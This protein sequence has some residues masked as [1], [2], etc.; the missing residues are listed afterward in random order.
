MGGKAHTRTTRTVPRRPAGHEAGSADE[1]EV[2]LDLAVAFE[3]LL[4]AV[5]LLA[6]AAGS[7]PD[8]LHELAELRAMLGKEE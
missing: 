6:R 1:H 7:P 8:V 3:H 4:T 5:G 2:H